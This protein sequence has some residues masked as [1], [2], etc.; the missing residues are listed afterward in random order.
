MTG[1]TFTSKHKTK[2]LAVILAMAALALA[3]QAHAVDIEN[4]D[5]RPHDITINRADGSSELLRVASGQR[6]ENIC[7]DCVV[8]L[9]DE[10][11]EA[12]G[13]VTIRIKDG[14]LSLKPAR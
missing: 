10:A 12:L 7:T 8:L 11:I 13:S 6:L 5:R 4:S 1:Q 3:P 2:C 9:H 14:K